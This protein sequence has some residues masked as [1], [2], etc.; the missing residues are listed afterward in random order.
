[1]SG[2]ASVPSD[3]DIDDQFSIERD[4]SLSQHKLLLRY[5]SEN[6]EFG[7][8]NGKENDSEYGWSMCETNH[9]SC[10]CQGASM[11]VRVPCLNIKGTYWTVTML[12][13]SLSLL[14]HIKKHND[15]TNPFHL[16]EHKTACLGFQ[17]KH[18]V[19][20]LGNTAYAAQP[21]ALAEHRMAVT[22]ALGQRV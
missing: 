17:F 16:D 21:C 8:E 6:K 5:D 13:M 12:A 14:H 15:L 3:N 4:H 2:S 19:Y 7:D 20:V 22:N 1:M 11:A 9:T 10:S 18:C